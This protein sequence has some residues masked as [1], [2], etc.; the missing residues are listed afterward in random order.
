M[1]SAG[2]QLSRNMNREDSQIGFGTRFGQPKRNYL[3]KIYGEPVSDTLLTLLPNSVYR[4]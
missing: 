2:R 3:Q 1:E 4:S